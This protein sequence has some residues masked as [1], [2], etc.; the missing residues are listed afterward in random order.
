M[1]ARV[2]R[3][4]VEGRTEGRRSGLFCSVHST[5]VLHCRARQLRFG[6]E[7]D[8]TVRFLRLR[9]CG[10]GAQ[11][12]SWTSQ[13]GGWEEGVAPASRSHVWGRKRRREGSGWA[14]HV[15]WGAA[16]VVEVEVEVV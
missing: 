3:A 9:C 13:M 16:V 12:Q 8:V 14:C 7:A 11:A 15:L 4:R 2:Q 1:R 5:P 10:E 6:P